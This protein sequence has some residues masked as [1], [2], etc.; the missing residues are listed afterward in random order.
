MPP[1]LDRLAKLLRQRYG[2]QLK[3]IIFF[4]SRARGEAAAESDYDC[5]LIF[6]QVTPE[7]NR[8]L[9]RLTGEWLVQEGVVF[10]YVV[11][12]EADLDRLRYEPFL[13]NARREGIAA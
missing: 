1:D 3:R 9:N 11:L 12:S 13:Q 5:L 10:S 8:D 4:G 6:Q 2:A 7:L